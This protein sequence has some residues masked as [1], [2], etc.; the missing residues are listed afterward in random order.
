MENNDVTLAYNLMLVDDISSKWQQLVNEKESMDALTY[1]DQLIDELIQVLDPGISWLCCLKGKTYLVAEQPREAAKCYIRC[2]KLRPT[3]FLAWEG[4]K[5]SLTLLGKSKWANDCDTGLKAYMRERGSLII[6]WQNFI[7][8]GDYNSAR[9]ILSDNR[10]N[11]IESP[12]SQE[13]RNKRLLLSD[14]I[15]WNDLEHI[16]GAVEADRI[17]LMLRE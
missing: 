2:L 8:S 17:S 4:L 16:L 15:V 12:I 3:S 6:K 1:L 11:I 10:W 13:K 9:S 14:S 7:K 5:E